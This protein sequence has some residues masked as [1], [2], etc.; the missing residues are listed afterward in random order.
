MRSEHTIKSHCNRFQRT[1]KSYLLTKPDKRPPVANRWP[2][3]E[4]HVFPLFDYHYGLTDGWTD[5]L[6]IGQ[7]DQ[8]TE[9]ASYRV[10]CLQLKIGFWW[11][12]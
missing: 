10:V 4:I 3:V 7:T 1:N 6:T 11:S 2:G 12:T 8:P 9:K 5:R